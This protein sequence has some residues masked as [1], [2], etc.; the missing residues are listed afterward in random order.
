MSGNADEFR[1]ALA[2]GNYDPDE[3]ITDDSSND[4]DDSSSDSSSSSTDIGGDSLQSGTDPTVDSGTDDRT[5]TATRQKRRANLRR[6]WGRDNARLG[7]DRTDT[8]QTDSGTTQSDSEGSQDGG[9]DDEPLNVGNSS[10]D[11]TDSGPLE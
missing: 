8:E 6:N 10:S 9:A 5:T 3:G 1:E 2:S 11:P 7:E 4:S